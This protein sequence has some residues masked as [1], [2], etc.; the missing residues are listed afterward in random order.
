MKFLPRNKLLL[1]IIFLVLLAAITAILSVRSGKYAIVPMVN[2]PIKP[3][4]T[5]TTQPESDISCTKDED[6]ELIDNSQPLCNFCGSCEAI[7][8]TNSKWI[9][10]NITKY[11]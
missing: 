10:V 2:S 1:M 11:T 8:Y 3:S 6:C 7:D 5:S 9:A 4:P